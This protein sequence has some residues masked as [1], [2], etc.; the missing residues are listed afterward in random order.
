MGVTIHIDGKLLGASE[1]DALLVREFASSP[2]W[3]M[4]EIREAQR[5]L[6]R[7]RNEQDW[8]YIGLTR[9]IVVYPH[10][11]AE[12]LRFEFDDNLYIQEYCK[13]QFAGPS[14]HVSI[15]ELMRLL[16]PLFETL[17]VQDEV[18]YWDTSD[19]SLLSQHMHRVDVVI[20]QLVAENPS[21]QVAVRLPSG[22]IVDWIGRCWLPAQGGSRLATNHSPNT[23]NMV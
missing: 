6:E 22:K 21:R 16:Q 2:R 10:D 13:T 8:D 9:G 5:V 11:N 15:V 4:E 12:P 3:P 1:Y 19:L 17:W 14:V 18:E 23:N 20:T 7:V